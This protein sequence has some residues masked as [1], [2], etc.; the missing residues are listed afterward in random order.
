MTEVGTIYPEIRTAITSSNVS[1]EVLL[2]N[3]QAYE[4]ALIIKKLDIKQIVFL[5]NIN[6]K[7][8]Y[9]VEL[10]T[11]APE[12]MTHVTFDAVIEGKNTVV[13]SAASFNA[14]RKDAFVFNTSYQITRT[15]ICAAKVFNGGAIKIGEIKN[16]SFVSEENYIPSRQSESRSNFDLKL[17]LVN[18]V[19]S[20]RILFNPTIGVA[21]IV[22]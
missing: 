18:M 10:T 19:G 2:V 9:F 12:G 22:D 4:S 15:R 13:A 6:G 17:V 3:Q 14:A 8:T 20:L 5:N 16:C 1:A 21:V 11:N 7:N